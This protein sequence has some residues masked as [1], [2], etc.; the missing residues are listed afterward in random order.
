VTTTPPTTPGSPSTLAAGDDA[1]AGPSPTPFVAFTVNVTITPLESP[2]TVQRVDE[3]STEQVL[4][5]ELVTV[6]PVI[7][8]P[9]AAA[10]DHDTFALRTPATAATF[11]AAPGRAAGVTEFDE[12]DAAPSPTEFDATTVKEYGVPFERSSTLQDVFNALSVVHDLPPG[13]AV[14]V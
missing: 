6:Y 5:S 7:A 4:P 10:A 14:T 12:S 8:E 9:F 11:D 3:P 13:D 1:E 2:S